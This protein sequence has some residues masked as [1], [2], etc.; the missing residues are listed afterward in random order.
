MNGRARIAR[1]SA[2][3]CWLILTVSVACWP[4]GRSGIGLPTTA[5]AFLPL[6]LPLSGIARGSRQ[7]YR[8]APLTLAPALALAVA[9]FL[10]NTPLRLRTGLSLALLFLAF[11]SLIA[12]LRT[13]PSD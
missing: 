7:T 5:L 4:F 1:R 3:A 11:A 8:W 9:E 6:L 13:A 12:A 2:I 10:I